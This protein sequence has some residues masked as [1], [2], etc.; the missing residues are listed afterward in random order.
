MSSRERDRWCGRVLLWKDAWCCHALRRVHSGDD[1]VAA[2]FNCG[3]R[4]WGKRCL[5]NN[6]RS[7]ES[8]GSWQDRTQDRDAWTNLKADFIAHVQRHHRPSSACRSEHGRCYADVAPP[9]G[10]RALV[11]RNCGIVSVCA[12]DMTHTSHRQRHIDSAHLR[13]VEIAGQRTHP[14]ACSASPIRHSSRPV[15]PTLVRSLLRDRDWP[16]RRG[17]GLDAVAVERPSA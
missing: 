5:D 1:A 11:H 15:E 17:G 9:V 7:S 16:G 8:S 13:A 3:Y 4:L 14:C 6:A 12:P 10:V 2:R